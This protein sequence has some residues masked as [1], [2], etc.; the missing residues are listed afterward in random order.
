MEVT[1]R[2]GFAECADASACHSYPV[3]GLKLK[4]LRPDLVLI[5]RKPDATTLQFVE[6]FD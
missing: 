6:F 3:C 4:Y 5:Y 2:R 1:G